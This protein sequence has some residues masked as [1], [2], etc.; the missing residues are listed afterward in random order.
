MSVDYRREQIANGIGISILSDKKFKTNS[1]IIRFL[2]KL[3]SETASIN[4]IIPMLLISTNDKYPTRTE[5]T[6]KVSSLYG[7]SLG[8]S[9]SKLS[10]VQIIALD[11]GCIRN[12]FALE[13][14]NVT[15]DLVQILLDCIFNPVIENDGFAPKEFNIRKQELIDMIDSQINNKRGYAIKKANEI[16]FKDEPFSVNAYGTKEQA[17]KLDA[18]SVYDAYKNLLE[19]AQIEIT[20]AGGGNL[21]PTVKLIKEAFTS[22]INRRFGEELNFISASTL[23]SEPEY[24]TEPMDMNQSKMVMAYKGDCSNIYVAKLM[25]AILGGTAFSKL[26]T[27][28]REKLSLC[29]YCAARIVDGKS[30]LLI[31]SGV[32]TANI[33][34]AQK[35]INEQ[36]QDI[37]N[38]NL[39]D[40]EIN[41]TKLAICGDFRSSYDTTWDLINWYFT[42]YT[43]GNIYSPEELIELEN[44][45]T[46]EEI[47]Q[48]AKSFKLDSVYVL[49]SSQKG[50]EN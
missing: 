4:A 29:Y 1:V 28:V 16:I 14:E 30:V 10:D 18:C 6:K 8:T 13:G 37:A 49:E 32:D 7:S 40:D 41:N 47:I 3:S 36:L 31:D 24:K 21:E 22:K 33:E 25:S 12:E 38:G 23:K 17:E 11:A 5:L 45:I 9:N 39:T 35:S 15:E 26:F 27:N 19:T 48:C 34:L 46:R 20:I 44:A 50:D 2:E 42:Q 43:R